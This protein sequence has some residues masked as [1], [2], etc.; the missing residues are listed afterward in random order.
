MI[1]GW[2]KTFVF[3]NAQHAGKAI[4]QSAFLFGM[5]AQRHQ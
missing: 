3:E 4:L 1:P 2:A 5:D